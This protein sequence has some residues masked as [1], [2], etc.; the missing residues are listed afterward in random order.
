M[1]PHLSEELWERLG[2]GESVFD[3]AM[4]QADPRYL[5]PETI[6][7]VIQVN[8]KIRAREAVAA[9]VDAA[10]MREIALAHPR[11]VEILGAR[12]PRKVIVIPKKLVNIVV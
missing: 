12:E 1:T 9:D 11:V 7:L 8:S 2:H 5:A 6:E 3:R 4:P 10:R